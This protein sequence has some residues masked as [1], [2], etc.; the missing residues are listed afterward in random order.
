M[1]E[2]NH[3]VKRFL[4]QDNRNHVV[5]AVNDVSFCL[6]DGEICALVGESGSG[7]S[8]LSHLL[9]GLIRA[10]EGEI[11]L[12]GTPI[13]PRAKKLNPKLCAEIQLVLQNSGSALDPRYSVYQSIA[14]PIRNLKPLPRKQEEEKIREL[15]RELDLPQTLIDRKASQLSGGQQKRVCI[16]RALAVEPRLV[17]F[18]EA[19]SGID[20]IMRKTLLDLLMRVHKKHMATYL[21]ITHDIEVALYLADHIMIMKNG[22]LIEQVSYRGDISCFSQDY[23]KLLLSTGIS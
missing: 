23:T 6:Q 13:S 9:T 2:A 19:V 17:I 10:D 7:K 4:S 16:A 5:H 3:L 18:D 15:M 21:I 14:E 22:K 1:L 8:T 20:V 12:N 11:L